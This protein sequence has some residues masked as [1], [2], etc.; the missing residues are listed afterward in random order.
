MYKEINMNS[1]L[2][3]MSGDLIGI[4]GKEHNF[5]DSVAVA[6]NPLDE[7]FW[8]T[9]YREMFPTMVEWLSVPA[10]NNKPQRAGWDRILLLSNRRF[11]VI[12]EKI[13]LKDYDDFLLEYVSVDT[14]NDPGWMEKDL[15]IDFIAY[16]F[17][18]S[19]EVHF[20]QWDMLRKAWK[21]NGDMWIRKYQNISA[22]NEGYFTKSVVVPIP[23]VKTAMEK[24]T[25]IVIP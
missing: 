13:R 17:R 9:A 21:K 11:V 15:A 12:D 8:E 18:P 4:N 25:H 23:V 1:D 14:R 5:D 20:L 19:R 22:K 2:I 16:A 6:G 24:S 10:G 3:G 7:P